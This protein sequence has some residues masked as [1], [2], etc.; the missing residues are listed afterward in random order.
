MG[1][2]LVGPGQLNTAFIL[3]AAMAG[4]ITDFY[5]GSRLDVWIHDSALVY[6][7][8]T[9]WKHAAI[10]VLDD[11]IPYMVG[12][13]QALPL[14]ALAADRLIEAGA[15]GVFLDAKISKEIENRMPYAECIEPSGNVRWSMPQCAIT[16][17]AQCLINNSPAGS[18]PLKMRPETIKKFSLAPYF[19]QGSTL[20][21][22]LLYGWEAAAEIP[23]RGLEAKERLVTDGSPVAR[24]LDL[25][26][27]SVVRRLVTF[28]KP[29]VDASYFQ[30]DNDAMCNAL[31]YCRR[32][33]LGYPIHQIQ[34]TGDRLV[35]PLSQIASCDHSSA[36]KLA[37]RTQSKVVVLQASTPTEQTDIFITPM[38]T[39]WFGP[40]TL[41]PGSQFIVDEV[42]TVLNQDHPRPPA[43]MIKALLFLL[44]AFLSVFVATKRPTLLWLAGL[45]VLVLLIMLCVLN[46]LVQLWPVFATMTVFLLGAG[47]AMTLNLIIGIKE[48]RL[49]KQYMPKQIHN[50][51]FS[52]KDGD[53]FRNK[54]CQAVVLMSDLAGYTTLTGILK[55]PGLILDLMNDYLSETAIVLQDKYN[56]WF[57]SYIGDMVCYYWPYDDETETVFNDAVGGAVEL[58]Q[59]Q[60]KFFASL[61]QRYANQMDAEIVRK[62]NKIINAGIGLTAGHVVMG[63][64]G[65][66]YGVRKFGILGDPLN[67]A[68]RVE[69]L[70]RHFNTEIIISGEF[71][72]VAKQKGYPVRRL[73]LIKVKGRLRPEMLYA[74]GG[75]DPDDL[76]F[77][78]QNIKRWE[79]WLKQI[80]QSQY[81]DLECPDI[82]RHDKETILGWQARNLLGD[83]K[84]WYLDEK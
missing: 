67:L 80:E 6:Q 63:N 42:E 75:N 21:D 51:L 10:V 50:L 16:Q 12:R 41:T 28:A 34:V 83:D 71:L 3:I 20:P 48:G 29:D 17:T 73:G 81:A 84:V 77:D 49:I 57:E 39:A 24:W 7:A 8:R 9:E 44:T 45:G 58:A 54:R 32:V 72:G 30:H 60:K 11:E 43:S 36:L 31:F 5:F 62:I 26:T 33:R 37:Q 2:F 55:E 22:F 18:A 69:S 13:K 79:Q 64:L 35:L 53:S 4:I 82:Y 59:L 40:D 61:S 78:S 1:N 52:I 23:G 76:R 19:R 66:K 56:G 15:R 47:Q 46:P 65:P 27:D 14:F 68:S 25:S 70:T 38:T 74:M